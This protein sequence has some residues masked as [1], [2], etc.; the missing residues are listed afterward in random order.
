MVASPVVFAEKY[1]D[2]VIS[3][4]DR[5]RFVIALLIGDLHSAS[6][7]ISGLES[8]SSNEKIFMNLAYKYL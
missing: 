4:R 1:G 3:E 8:E 5:G 7:K 2:V 6:I